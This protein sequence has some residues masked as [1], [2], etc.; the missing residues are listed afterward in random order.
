MLSSRKTA[1]SRAEKKLEIRKAAL[2]S[3]KREGFHGVGMDDICN[4]VKMQPGQMYRYLDQGKKGIIASVVEDRAKENLKEIGD[5][6][7]QNLGVSAETAVQDFVKSLLGQKLKNR[8][9]LALDLE[10]QAEAMRNYDVQ[11]LLLA[12][13]PG[14]VPDA[15]LSLIHTAQDEDQS[16]KPS[17]PSCVAFILVNVINQVARML[18]LD[19]TMNR[20]KVEEDLKRI[21]LAILGL[22]G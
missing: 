7:T 1:A 21:S 11:L 20:A 3:Y 14:N 17:D 18:A 4:R 22:G 6:L 9:D 12:G 10:I 8:L 19:E 13:L 15:L 2:A 16:V 5:A